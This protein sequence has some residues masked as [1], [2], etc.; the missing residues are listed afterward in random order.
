LLNRKSFEINPKFIAWLPEHQPKRQPL[1]CVSSP[2]HTLCFYKTFLCFLPESGQDR[3][4]KNLFVFRVPFSQRS[5][6]RD[7]DFPAFSTAG[8]K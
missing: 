5:P 4:N 7:I 2:W 3:K 1:T 6:I 8:E